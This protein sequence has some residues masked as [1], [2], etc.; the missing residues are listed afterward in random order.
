MT[1]NIKETYPTLT[2][3]IKEN[4]VSFTLRNVISYRPETNSIAECISR[5]QLGAK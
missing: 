2:Y 3:I 4:F 5:A 1:P